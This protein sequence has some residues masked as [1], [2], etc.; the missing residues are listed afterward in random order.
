MTDEDG[1]G[2]LLKECREREEE[3]VVLEGGPVD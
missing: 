1:G 3:G 2:G